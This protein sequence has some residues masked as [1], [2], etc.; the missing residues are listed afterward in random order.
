MRRRYQAVVD[1]QNGI[2]FFS[3]LF[4]SRNTAVVLVMHH[5]HQRQFRL[6]FS[7]GQSF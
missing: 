7:I 3:P 4:V 5:V 2:P 1:C 6:H